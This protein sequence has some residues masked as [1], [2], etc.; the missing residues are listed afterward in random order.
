MWAPTWSKNLS[1]EA[2]RPETESAN[3]WMW[4]TPSPWVWMPSTSCVASCS[5]GWNSPGTS[6][7]A[8]IVVEVVD[9]G[10]VSVVAGNVV[11]VGAVVVVSAGAVVVVA[12][13]VGVCVAARWPAGS[14]RPDWLLLELVVLL[15]D[16]VSDDDELLL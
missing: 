12:P 7:G 5:A 15:D 6:P 10:V 1:S 16:D 13:V 2:R 11:S 8:A 14:P 4:I 3:G 9:D